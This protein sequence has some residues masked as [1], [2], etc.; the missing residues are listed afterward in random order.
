MR[1]ISLIF[2]GLFLLAGC[3]P[4]EIYVEGN[5]PPTYTDIPTL[6]VE[7][8]VNSVFIDM[9]GRAATDEERAGYVSQLES[10]GNSIAARKAFVSQLQ[11][12]SATSSEFFY[13][14]YTDLKGRYLNSS[15]DASIQEEF[16]TLAYIAH[17]DS[18]QGNYLISQLEWV[19]ANKVLAVLNIPT[20][21]RLNGLAFND[22]CRIMMFNSIYDDLN[23]GTFNFVN[24]SFD[25]NFFRYPTQSEYSSVYNAIEV[26]V[27]G[28]FFGQTISSKQDY[29]DVLIHS[30][31]FYEGAIRWMYR[32]YMSRDASDNEVYTQLDMMA[33]TNGY[34]TIQ[35]N[36]FSSD[37]YAGF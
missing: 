32:S 2:I 8:Y 18:L 33:E 24:A 7:Q 22:A 1:H 10:A 34:L 15:T 37:E 16:T 30:N 4:E 35:Q 14:L 19:E 25:Q 31:E 9:L 26:N 11:S 3:K 27:S 29:L 36:I 28:V 23:M 20:N 21:M 13:K 17:N 6:R 12:N 5:T